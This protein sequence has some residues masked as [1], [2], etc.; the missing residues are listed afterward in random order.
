MKPYPLNNLGNRKSAHIHARQTKRQ[1]EPQKLLVVALPHAS[2]KPH[3]VVI[4]MSD[5][6][7]TH[8]A[9]SRLNRPEDEAGLTELDFRHSLL[10]ECG[11]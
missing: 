8:V 3:A 6:V 1:R 2:A 4:E 9:V 7:I 11:S 5:A 10:S